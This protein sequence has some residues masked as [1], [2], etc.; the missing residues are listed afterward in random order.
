MSVVKVF[1]YLSIYV[2]V[3]FPC[4]LQCTVPKVAETLLEYCPLKYRSGLYN[5][6]LIFNYSVWVSTYQTRSVVECEEIMIRVYLESDY[7]MCEY[8]LNILNRR[9]ESVIFFH[10]HYIS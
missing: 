4:M 3:S 5:E 1:E 8:I 2:S 6:R 9:Q 10:F 7:H